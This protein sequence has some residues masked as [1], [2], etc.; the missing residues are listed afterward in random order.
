M[1]KLIF[2]LVSLFIFF[3]GIGASAQ[4]LVVV[5]APIESRT[6]ISK[7][8][9]EAIEYLLLN[10][11]SKYKPTIKVLDQSDAMFKA[12]VK[13][14]EFELSD[15]SNPKKVAG[16]GMALNANAIVL[17]RIMSLGNDPFISV[18][19]N[20]LTT[21]IKAAN[22]MAFT[23]T[24]EVRSKLSVFVKEIINNLPKPNP[25]LGRWRSTIT[26]NK[27]TLTCILVFTNDGKIT[28]ERYDTN[29]VTEHLRGGRY[30]NDRK[31]GRGSGTYSWNGSNVYIS[32][33]LSNVSHEFTAVNAE[34]YI[35]KNNQF[36]ADSMNCEWYDG[37]M[38]DCYEIFYKF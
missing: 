20:D 15:W 10:E 8:D 22:D 29:K 17:V 38:N 31:R 12:I 21:E 23:N 35:Y 24:S 32:L 37:D 26:S 13:Q 16:F 27:E 36:K 18:R 28:V 2:W 34:G 9:V 7:G 5:I 3:A 19:I 14:M 6:D 33:T 11:L 30:T 4:E 1:K 25:F